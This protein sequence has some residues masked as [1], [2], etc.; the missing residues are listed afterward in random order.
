MTNHSPRIAALAWA[1]E[2][3]RAGRDDL[4]EKAHL[5]LLRDVVSKSNLK[6]GPTE[7][8]LAGRQSITAPWCITAILATVALVGLSLV[9]LHYRL[10]VGKSL[11][12]GGTVVLVA[13]LAVV[14]PAKLSWG[15]TICSLVG[16]G[17]VLRMIPPI[18]LPISVMQ[19][20]VAAGVSTLAL[21]VSC[22][23]RRMCFEDLPEIVSKFMKGIERAMTSFYEWFQQPR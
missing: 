15:L 14:T 23:H 1:L 17:I 22:V 6:I 21:I 8:V 4:T 7:R 16:V 11:W 9:L 13:G 12:V 3:T 10:S 20:I 18:L 2:S 19:S 5:I